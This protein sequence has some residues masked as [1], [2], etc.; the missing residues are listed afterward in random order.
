[1]QVQGGGRFAYRHCP[2]HNYATPSIVLLFFSAFFFLIHK[3]FW[4]NFPV[5]F[6]Q[7]VE[8]FS[9]G[10]TGW[11][12]QCSCL[13]WFPIHRHSWTKRGE[14]FK[15]KRLQWCFIHT[16]ITLR[17]SQSWFGMWW[18]YWIWNWGC[19]FELWIGLQLCPIFSLQVVTLVPSPLHETRNQGQ[20]C[21]K[22]MHMK[23]CCRGVI[24]MGSNG[25]PWGRQPEHVH[26]CLLGKCPLRTVRYASY[27]P[28][29]YL[30]GVFPDNL[31]LSC[32]V[33]IGMPF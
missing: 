5:V 25:F 10:V 14:W 20:V 18:K 3:K 27:E 28:H 2:Y 17:I 15:E 7:V 6:P 33:K 8:F 11:I 19:K 4:W 31:F 21:S 9:A 1:M 23:C 32:S 12:S 30:W 22:C 13:P 26:S 29:K 24:R 16:H